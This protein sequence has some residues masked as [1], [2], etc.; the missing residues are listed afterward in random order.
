MLLLAHG[1]VERSQ[2]KSELLKRYDDT[3][4]RADVL[5]KEL[6]KVRKHSTLL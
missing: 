6:D 5:E 1:V 3:I 4:L 2:K